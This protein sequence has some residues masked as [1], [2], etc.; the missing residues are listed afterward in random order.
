MSRDDKRRTNE[1]RIDLDTV[2]E[3]LAY[4]HHDMQRS[5]RL[6]RV[7]DA[8]A[9]VLAEI[10]AVEAHAAAEQPQPADVSRVVAFPALRPRFVA[11]S[12]D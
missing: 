10:A 2:R 1:P 3:T 6:A 4:M 11:W 8:L 7:S 9:V 5:R 12:P